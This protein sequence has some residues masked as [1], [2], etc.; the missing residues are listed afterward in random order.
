MSH[1]TLYAFR[2]EKAE[3]G[4][5]EQKKHPLLTCKIKS[6]EDLPTNHAI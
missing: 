4:P 6:V 1:C 2:Q 5:N 3:T